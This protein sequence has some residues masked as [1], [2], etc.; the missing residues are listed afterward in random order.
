MKI[1]CKQ[2]NEWIGWREEDPFECESNHLTTA[3]PNST[4]FM[5]RC[6]YFI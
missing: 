3:P 1:V 6:I 2:Q 5:Y 4:N